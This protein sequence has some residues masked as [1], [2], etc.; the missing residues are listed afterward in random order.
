M[1]AVK[2]GVLGVFIGTVVS[3]FSLSFWVEVYVLFKDGLKSKVSVYFIDYFKKMLF[4]LVIGFGLY[5]LCSFITGNLL[6]KFII[7]CFL[8]LIIP[9]LIF[10]FVY[11][12]CDEFKYF[13]TLFLD[14][15]NKL[16]IKFIKN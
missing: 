2:F 7:K 3:Y 13:K 10:V 4:T 1:L 16:K 6:F 9:N 15:V 8:C 11:R 12:K 5:Y 14:I